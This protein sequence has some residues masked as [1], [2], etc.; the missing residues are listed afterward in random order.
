MSA[1]MAKYQG[2]SFFID[3]NWDRFLYAATIVVALSIG[4]F[5][6]SLSLP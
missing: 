1:L 6:G 5:I 4:A 3:V 2:L